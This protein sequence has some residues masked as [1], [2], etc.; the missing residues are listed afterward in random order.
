[1]NETTLKIWEMPEI[2]ALNRLQAHASFHHFASAETALKRD[3]ASTPWFID[4]NGDW[5]FRLVASPEEP[6]ALSFMETAIETQSWDDITVPGNW[7]TQCFDH[8]HYTNSLMPF[9]DYPPHVPK[10]NPT[11]LYRT[12]F[13]L[14]KK[15]EKRRTVIH[16]GGVESAFFV[17]V[18]GKE[19]G[20]A[21]DSRTPSE[22]DIT[23]YLVSGENTLA[24]K[25]IRW[26]DGSFIE[27]QDHWWMAGIFRGVYLYSTPFVTIQDVFCTATP[28][29]DF[30]DGTLKLEV[31]VA[32]TDRQPEPDWKISTAVFGPDG[33]PVPEGTLELPVPES[34][35]CGSPN[36]GNRV[37]TT[38]EFA[39]PSLWS[40]ETPNLY[41]LV[42]TLLAPDGTATDIT[43][44]RFG[45]RSIAIRDRQ[46]L[47]NGKP[48]L[49]K[50][51]NRHDFHERYGKTVP[52][53]TMMQDI[54]LLKQYNFNAVRTSHYPNDE[55]WYDLCDEYGIYLI[56]EANIEAH[57]YYG[58]IC[59]DPRWTNAFLYR[60]M[61]MVLRDKNHPS[62]IFWS[63]GNE[64]GYGANQ[65]AL[66]GWIRGYDP[67]RPLHCEGVLT[68]FRQGYNGWPD[69]VGAH[70]TDVIS[71]MYP[72]ID[73][74]R[75]WSSETHD[76]RP[77]ICCE[78]S[79]A[80]G[81]SN[82]NL[83]E[84]FE[85]FETLPGLQGGFIWD[86]V[87]QGLLCL[88]DQN[89]QYWGYG[90]DYGD[91]PNDK[92]FCINGLI[93]PDRTPHPAMNEFKKLAQP[94]AVEAL[95]LN[96]GSLRIR[97]KR[98]FLNLS[99]LVCHW[100]LTTGQRTLQEGDL[101]LP[102]IPPQG[103][104]DVL[105]DT[106]QMPE[107]LPGEEAFL[108]LSFTTRDASA[109]VPAGHEVAWEQFAMPFS[110]PPDRPA[111]PF[112]K[113]Q[114][115]KQKELTQIVGRHFTLSVNRAD[116]RIQSYLWN[117][118]ALIL[119]GPQ[120]N[121]W[122]AP[123]DNDGV[124]QFTN[125]DHKPLGRWI[126]A[127]YESLHNQTVACE[128]DAIDGGAVIIDIT[129]VWTGTDP[130]APIC[131]QHR[132]LVLPDGQILVENLIT[133]APT[134]PDLPRIG[135]KMTLD[136]SLENLAWFGRGPHETYCDRKAGARI[137]V[138]QSTVTEQYVPYVVP[139]EH[140][141][142]TDV[143]WMALEAGPSDA[144]LLFQAE[145]RLLEC[146]VSHY[147]A[148]E[149]TKACHINEIDPHGEIFLN[150][151]YGQRGLGGASCGPDALPK[152]RL[153]P[154]IYSFSYRIIPYTAE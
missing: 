109:A 135:V 121:I 120:L 38:V 98:W 94:V 73:Y 14:P 148:Y 89:R 128:L 28:H 112:G 45:F 20:F 50:G 25:V 147:D 67:S 81:N 37:E 83:R 86:W 22:F 59:D 70:A 130:D 46:L 43:S 18:N 85:A 58:N 54:M 27:D 53:E 153:E 8:P 36:R 101:E 92:N 115:K 95:N 106:I 51:V 129:N 82:G 84:Y 2:C 68:K 100:T 152:Y 26:S 133:V 107:L 118:K 66:A 116:G 48:V 141:N 126:K 123:T 15:W 145:N 6:E 30:V 34:L 151:D 32:F 35:V 40:D 61:N 31:R 139:Q 76:W 134:L 63:L 127:G 74:L 62:V 72:A 99:D 77:L 33:S 88:D 57:H 131:H 23:S 136:P 47:I 149:L 1:M 96:Q 119:D 24:V 21:K 78:Y 124:K 111:S 52:F 140:G 108:N 65:D 60:G 138:W 39:K 87:D 146:S 90:G 42:V 19:C 137:G 110:A 3:P 4:L 10:D 16:F 143:R 13:S 9:P 5:K 132:Y 113:V 142:H 69:G 154:G 75:K 56:D 150:I 97:N 103:S 102:D 49:I 64:T 80:M 55:A 11:G 122:R 144:G 17:Y 104:A 91:T 93:W 12:T 125:Q 44:V 71:P 7:T 105:I 29:D 114:L 41:T 117:G 79:H